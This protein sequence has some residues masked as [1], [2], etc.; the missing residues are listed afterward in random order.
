ATSAVTECVS[1][2][3]LSPVQCTGIP[4]SCRPS[5]AGPLQCANA[6]IAPPRP[7]AL[8]PGSLPYSTLSALS[9]A[10]PP[11]I[12]YGYRPL[13]FCGKRARSM[14]RGLEEVKAVKVCDTLSPP[15]SV[16][17]RWTEGCLQ[18]PSPPARTHATA[19]NSAGRAKIMPVF[20][21][22]DEGNH[23][24]GI[25]CTETQSEAQRPTDAAG[26]SAARA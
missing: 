2:L 15:G 1:S 19:D 13:G 17:H 22:Q 12:V 21:T 7:E 20:G 11:T 26:A 6:N 14:Y 18:R 9:S 8:F 16:C 25:T 3:L 4:G 24:P 10:R 5:P 23:S